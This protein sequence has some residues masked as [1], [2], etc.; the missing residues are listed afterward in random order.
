MTIVSS[1]SDTKELTVC[2]QMLRGRSAALRPAR[3]TL[4]LG[5]LAQLKHEGLR[6]S[7]SSH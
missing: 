6:A 4:A 3:G 1:V 7:F 2:C 5:V